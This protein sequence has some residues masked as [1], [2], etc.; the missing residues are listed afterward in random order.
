MPN[1]IH[2]V[3]PVGA[4]YI[5]PTTYNAPTTSNAQNTGCFKPPIYGDPVE[6]NRFN[7]LP[8]IILRTF[9]G[10]VTRIAWAQYIAPLPIVGLNLDAVWENIISTIGYFS[11]DQD[12]Y[13]T[14]RIKID[15]ERDKL[16]RQIESLERQMKATKQPRRKRDLFVELQWLKGGFNG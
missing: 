2:M 4:Q 8:A 16:L 15:E 9:K 5:A 10:A 12:K 13:L 11:V 6:D 3:I 1:H 7:S 14:E